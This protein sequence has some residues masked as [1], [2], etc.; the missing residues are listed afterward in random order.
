MQNKNEQKPSFWCS[1]N[2]FRRGIRDKN[3]GRKR[4]PNL[5]VAQ[6]VTM[7]VNDAKGAGL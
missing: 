7:A 2:L 3:K 5:S 4:E 6:T 1:E